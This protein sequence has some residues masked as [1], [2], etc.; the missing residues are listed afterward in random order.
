MGPF[1]HT[2]WVR[3]WQIRQQRLP[4]IGLWLGWAICSAFLV[5]IVQCQLAPA[6]SAQTPSDRFEEILPLSQAH[7]L[8]ASLT[9]WQDVEPAGDYFSE[10]QPTKL[11][12]LIWSNFPVKVYV[13]PVAASEPEH[14]RA[15]VWVDAVQQAVMEWKTYLP[16]TLVDSS[17]SADIA[18]LRETPQLKKQP[19]QPLRASSAETTY[20]FYVAESAEA[21]QILSHRYRI[22]LRPGQTATYL[23]AA[24]RHELGHAL[25]IWGHS[26]VETDVLYFS[27]VRNPPPISPRDV[28]TLK[29]IYEQPTRLGWELRQQVSEQ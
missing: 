20:E 9:Q 18:I 10:I 7:P 12:Y 11:G 26:P 27:Q 25:G 16:L 6:V 3:C 13:E 22:L 14:S 21:T 15:Q 19:G 23:L 29:R 1:R 8:P 17:E 5:L 24:A 4:R 28:N 2:D